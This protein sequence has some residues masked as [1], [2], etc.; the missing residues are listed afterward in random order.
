[1][2]QELIAQCEAL[3]RKYHAGQLY[4]GK[5][6]ADTHLADVARRVAEDPKAGPFTK[7]AAWLH[8][9]VEDTDIPAM[10]LFTLPAGVVELIIM[11]TRFPYETYDEYMD[12][13]CSYPSAAR[14]KYHDSASNYAYGGREKYAKN[15]ARLEAV[16]SIKK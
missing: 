10:E 15:M 1:M 5:D 14:I 9:V 6:Y 16:L 11:L 12:K 8:D 4:D 7:A 13:I 2:S 3:A